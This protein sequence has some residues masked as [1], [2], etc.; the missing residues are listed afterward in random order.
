MGHSLARNE[1][2]GID[3]VQIPLKGFAAQLIPERQPI[4]Y[5]AEIP[6]VVAYALVIV[7]GIIIQPY[8]G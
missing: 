2:L 7:L 5:I 8:L 1:E 6:L 3:G 4:R